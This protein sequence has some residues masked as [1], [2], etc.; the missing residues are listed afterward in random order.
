MRIPLILSALCL[1][2]AFLVPIS[3][4]HDARAHA[5]ATG[6]VKERMDAFSQARQQMKEIGGAL[7]SNNNE[8]VAELSAK[9]LPWAE[10]MGDYFPEGTDGAP[11]EASAAI[12]SDPDGFAEK[13]AAY[14][15]ALINLNEIAL[16]NGDTK[17]AFGAV[18]ASCKSCHRAYRN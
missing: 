16:A 11:S 7:R 6:I 2:L 12:W 18:S 3:L 8:M 5:G 4:S 13:I 15:Q 17:T 10:T 1:T 9:M 14:R